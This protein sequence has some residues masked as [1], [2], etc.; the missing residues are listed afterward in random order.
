MT[1]K[2]GTKI[3]F[4]RCVCEAQHMPKMRLQ[5]GKLIALPGPLS[6]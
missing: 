2:I 3:V 5:P 4:A 1:G 6:K